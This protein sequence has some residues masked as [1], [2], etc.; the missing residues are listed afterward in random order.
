VKDRRIEV[1]V[2]SGKNAS[3]EDEYQAN[4][5]RSQAVNGVP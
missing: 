5:T 1:C 2:S 3:V 4:G